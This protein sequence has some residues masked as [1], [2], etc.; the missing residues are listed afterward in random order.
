MIYNLVPQGL[1][2]FVSGT[3]LGCCDGWPAGAAP[4]AGHTSSN[5]QRASSAAFLLIHP[6]PVACPPRA[7]YACYCKP[8]VFNAVCKLA[9]LVS[10]VVLVLGVVLVW[11]L[12]P[13]SYDYSQVRGRVEEASCGAAGTATPQARRACS[14]AVPVLHPPP[15]RLPHSLHRPWATACHSS[16]RSARASCRARPLRRGAPLPSPPTTTPPSAWRPPRP[17]PPA[18]ASAR[19]AGRA[20]GAG[21][22][23]AEGEGG[24][25]PSRIALLRSQTPPSQ[26][27]PCP[28]PCP[29]PQQQFDAFGGFGDLFGPAGRRLHQ[30]DPFA[31]PFAGGGSSGSGGGGGADPFAAGSGGG[32]DPFAISSSSGSDP[33]ATSVPSAGPAAAAAAAVPWDLG[34]GWFSG[35]GGG[36]L[37]GREGGSERQHPPAC[38]ALLPCCSGSYRA[39]ARTPYR[40][41]QGHHPHRLHHHAAGLG[42][43]DIWLRL[44]GTLACCWRCRALALPQRAPATPPATHPPHISPAPRRHTLHAQ[45]AGQAG[46]ALDQIRWGSD[47]LL[48]VHK[49]LP[50]SN[51]SLLVTRVGDIDTEV[52]LWYRPEEAALPRPAWA[53]D[54]T[55]GGSGEP[56]V[57]GR[58]SRVVLGALLGS[59]RSERRACPT[60]S[61]LACPRLPP[62]TWAGL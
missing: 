46:A 15:T 13:R 8:L 33:F 12:Y 51:Q 55:T 22:V 41:H 19:C 20:S 61:C 11:L 32:A 34:G 53:V 59:K 30:A 50:E 1:L 18:S 49:A 16:T 2:L 3:G 23:L 28:C 37:G 45:A 42:H 6:A 44:Q 25:R 57:G 35:M 21:F 31:D 9:M 60:R 26:P 4:G 58:G 29:R 40:Q 27:C 24:G 36:R 62:Q 43:D 7:Q 47:Y 17:T 14:T 39:A 48:K 5:K 54:L 38:V 56:G 10:T 52:L